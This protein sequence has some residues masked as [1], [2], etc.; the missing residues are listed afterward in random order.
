LWLGGDADDDVLTGGSGRDWITGGAGQD[1]LSGAQG[2]DILN[3][4]ADNETIEGGA[5]ADI[6]I[7]GYGLDLASYATS[8][9]GVN[10]DLST[11]TAT[12][13]DAEGDTLVGIEGIIGSGADDYLVGNAG[14]NEFW[15]GAGVDYA[16]GGAGD[17]VYHFGVGDGTLIIDEN[18]TNDVEFVGGNDLLVFGAGIGIGDLTIVPTGD[19]LAITIGTSGDNITL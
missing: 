4:G 6:I 14:G 11:G 3:G 2:D 17:D 15:G 12:D 1:T 8:I 13:G 18:P 5:G 10:I 16:S 19:D 7:G 9:N